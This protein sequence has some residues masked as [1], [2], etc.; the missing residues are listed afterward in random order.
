MKVYCQNCKYFKFKPLFV[1]DDCL[2]PDNYVWADDWRIHYRERVLL[3]YE[4]N[5]NN[6]C[7]LYI[8]KKKS[9]IKRLWGLA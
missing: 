8:Q 2:A 7:K 5:V 9:F 6:D 3:P 1:L 4:R